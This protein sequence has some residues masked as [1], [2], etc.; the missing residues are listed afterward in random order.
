MKFPPKFKG[1]L[2]PLIYHNFI[3][4]DQLRASFDAR[5]Q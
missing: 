2:F 1:G 4:I 5:V 3:Y